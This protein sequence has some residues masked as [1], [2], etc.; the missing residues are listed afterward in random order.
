M[1]CAVNWSCVVHS[2]TGQNKPLLALASQL[3]G[4]FIALRHIV[5]TGYQHKRAL[6]CPAVPEY[7]GALSFCWHKLFCCQGF[8]S[9][10]LHVMWLYCRVQL[11]SALES[12]SCCEWTGA[13]KQA[14]LCCFMYSRPCVC[15]G[16]WVDGCMYVRMY[17][18]IY[19][20]LY[21]H[22]YKYMYMYK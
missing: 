12:W 18:C 20:R 1:D 6:V 2:I 9:C 3:I 21:M 4:H 7:I 16:G 5:T 14:L 11:S 17:V 10:V 15:M 19:V 22:I 13:R 8:K